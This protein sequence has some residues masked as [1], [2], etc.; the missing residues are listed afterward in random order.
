MKMG[1]LILVMCLQALLPVMASEQDIMM[2]RSRQTFPEAMTTLQ[3][4]IIDH[5]YT[6]S[7]VQRVDIGLEKAGYKTDR[8]RIVFFGKHKEIKAITDDY[9]EMGAYLPLKVVIFAEEDETMLVALN[10]LH[11]QQ[12]IDQPEYNIIFKRWANDIKSIMEDVRKAD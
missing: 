3:N 5:Q 4:S 12:I 1:I 6:L 10:P 9:P 8:Y 2:I 7:R 11:F